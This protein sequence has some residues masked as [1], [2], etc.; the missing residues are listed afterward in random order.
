LTPRWKNSH[1]QMPQSR[2]PPPGNRQASASGSSGI[3]L[4]RP[5]D[6]V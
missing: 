6:V 4:K 1:Q 5:L 2:P 3:G